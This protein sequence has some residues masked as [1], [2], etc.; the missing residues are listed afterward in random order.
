MANLFTQLEE[1]N[2]QIPLAELLRPKKLEDYLGQSNVVA[3]NSPL[4]NLL[5]TNRLFSL[6]LWGTPGCGKTTLARLIATQTN[7]QFIEI[8]AV[9]SGVKDIKDTVESAKTALRNGVKTIL[10]IDEIH[11]YSKTQQ[12]A[13]LPHLENGTL[14]MI[15]ST[16]ENPSFQVIPALL[17]RVQVIRLNP[18]NDESIK[19]I[20]NKGFSYLAEEHQK[21]T[22]DNDVEKFIINYARGDA[23]A[24]LNLVENSY[25]ASN[26]K[27]NERNLTVEILEQITQR[28]NTR[29]SRQEHY[30]CA[31]AFQKSLRGSDADAA[32]YYLAKMIAAGED[33][34]FIARR[35]IVTASEDVGN[36]NPNALNIAVSAYKAVELLGLPEGRIPLA[37]A[38]IYVAKS[39]K[40]NSTIC[41]IDSA[42]QDIQ[43]GLD[44]PPPM[45]LRDAH[46]K[47]AAK[48]GF[49]EGY[50]YSHAH[51]DEYQQFLPD[52]L[53]DKK[54]VKPLPNVKVCPKN[55]NYKKELEKNN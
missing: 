8:S 52:E 32:I 44:F 31:S 12:D 7:S 33:P 14:Y 4:L 28:R 53:K 3:K 11:R 20:I 51:P 26:L 9:T 48:Y 40:S 37:Q 25:F 43:N 16:T 42:L 30:D 29:Y 35:L 39:P 49:G 47:D 10:F 2:K 55:E 36:A 5:Q 17:S 1:Q 45:H 50:L 38:V 19:N 13:L 34:R 18:L 6:I 27:D 15:G 41:A 54:Y 22:F 23:R 24:A 21:I 46:Y